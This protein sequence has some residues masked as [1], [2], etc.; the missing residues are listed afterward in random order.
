[1]PAKLSGKKGKLVSVHNSE[2]KIE[3]IQV[4]SL[5][6]MNLKKMT[7]NTSTTIMCYI[8]YIL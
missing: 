4:Q 3:N 2:F 5:F 7:L 6:Y 1:M 8:K